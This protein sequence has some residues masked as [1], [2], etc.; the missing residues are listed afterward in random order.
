L[1]DSFVNINYTKGK[2]T[3]LTFHLPYKSDGGGRWRGLLAHYSST[4]SLSLS[5]DL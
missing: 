2:N 5:T 3:N 1:R 4:L